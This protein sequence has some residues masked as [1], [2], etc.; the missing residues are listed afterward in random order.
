MRPGRA[1]GATGCSSARAP[2]P[3]QPTLAGKPPMA[4][5]AA[6]DSAPITRRCR[7]PACVIIARVRDGRRVERSVLGHPR[8]APGKWFYPIA[9]P[10]GLFPGGQHYLRSGLAA[11]ALCTTALVACASVYYRPADVKIGNC[12]T[13][14]SSSP[15]RGRH[16][17]S[18]GR[19]PVDARSWALISSSPRRGRYARSKSTACFAPCGGWFEP[20]ATD[21]TG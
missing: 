9:A 17:C 10:P 7:P 1:Q 15:R 8:R 6:I 18:H 3:L 21:S 19:K 13:A 2:L 5:G 20:A 14:F 4:P 12:A 11:K 16:V